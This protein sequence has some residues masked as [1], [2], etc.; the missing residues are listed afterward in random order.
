[1]A[2]MSC[3]YLVQ[4]YG[5]VGPGLRVMQGRPG[6]PH[7]RTDMRIRLG[8]TGVIKA[9]QKAE[10]FPEWGQGFRRFAKNKFASIAG[11]RKPAPFLNGVFRSGKGHAIGRIQ[12][13]KSPWDPTVYFIAHGF[14]D[15]QSQSNATRPTQKCPPVQFSHADHVLAPIRTAASGNFASL[16]SGSF[17]QEQRTFYHQMDHIPDLITRRLQGQAIFFQTFK[18]VKG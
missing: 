12:G 18:L 17:F 15:R 5:V 1:M 11:G 13:A 14:Q 2:C 7:I 9:A 4:T 16:P 8:A 10:L 6:E 3:D